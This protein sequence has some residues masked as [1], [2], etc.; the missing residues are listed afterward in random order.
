MTAE[1]KSAINLIEDL[2]CDEPLLSYFY[3]PFFAQR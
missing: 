2:V 1:E 3:D